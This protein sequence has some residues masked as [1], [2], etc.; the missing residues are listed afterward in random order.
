M[1]TAQE[2]FEKAV[3]EF[4]YPVAIATQEDI[5]WIVNPI[6]E[7]L[8]DW[9]I[10]NRQESVDKFGLGSIHVITINELVDKIT[11]CSETG[12]KEKQ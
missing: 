1:N 11:S 3:K 5:D 7:A 9:L 8:K 12:N 6:L 10:H 2:Y 4:V